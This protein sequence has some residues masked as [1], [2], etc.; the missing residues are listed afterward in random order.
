[1]NFE[2]QSCAGAILYPNGYTW[3]ANENLVWRNAYVSL[4]PVDTQD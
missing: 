4:S 2:N 3:T 1:M